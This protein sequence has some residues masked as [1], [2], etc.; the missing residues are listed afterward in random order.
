MIFVLA[1][2][3]CIQGTE[4]S[5]CSQPPNIRIYMFIKTK[6]CHAITQPCC[7]QSAILPVSLGS[8]SWCQLNQLI[9]QSLDMW[10]YIHTNMC[11]CILC[12]HL[13]S[14]LSEHTIWSM[15]KTELCSIEVLT[16][17]GTENSSLENIYQQ[18][19]DVQCFL[20]HCFTVAVCFHIHYLP[21]IGTMDI[22]I[23]IIIINTS[24]SSSSSLLLSS[25]FSFRK[26]T[27]TSKKLIGLLTRGHPVYQW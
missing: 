1:N 4:Q 8:L 18:W 7:Y 19:K 27:W 23:I 2:Q 13:Q 24:S 26:R 3:T 15:W 14:S 22:I 6:G 20:V 11:A 10:L 5:W 17:Q 21:E 25:S 12:K 16:K 9:S